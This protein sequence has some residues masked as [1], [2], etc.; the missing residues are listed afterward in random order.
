ME[1]ESA[2]SNGYYARSKVATKRA[3]FPPTSHPRG[4][5]TD[6]ILMPSSHA[7]SCF[8][9]LARMIDLHPAFGAAAI[10]LVSK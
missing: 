2:F 7:V 9:L 5:K 3:K 10:A 4:F 6:L 1:D 8:L